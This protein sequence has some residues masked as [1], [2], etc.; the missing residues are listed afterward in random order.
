M[1][2]IDVKIDSNLTPHICVTGFF[3]LETSES[4]L[5][6]RIQSIKEFG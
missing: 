2:N 3:V 6:S 4:N 1:K 5:V